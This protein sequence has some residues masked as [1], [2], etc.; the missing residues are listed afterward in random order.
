MKNPKFANTDSESQV[1]YMSEDE[2]DKLK[3]YVRSQASVSGDDCDSKID[4]EDDVSLH[5]SFVT[6]ASHMSQVEPNEKGALPEVEV[7][8]DLSEEDHLVIQEGK[9]REKKKKRRRLKKTKASIANR[10]NDFD[11]MQNFVVE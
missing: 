1:I 2:K 9:E 7:L 11:G 3:D 6:E 10:E 4:I 5:S 8:A